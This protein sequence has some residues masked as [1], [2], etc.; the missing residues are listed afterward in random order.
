M[1]KSNRNRKECGQ[2]R[3]LGTGGITFFKSADSNKIAVF[4]DCTEMFIEERNCEVGPLI[5]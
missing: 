4:C 1:E 3:I 2:S 5:E